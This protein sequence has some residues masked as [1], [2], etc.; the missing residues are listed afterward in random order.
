MLNFLMEV[1]V[2]DYNQVCYQTLSFVLFLLLLWFFS[3]HSL[4]SPP[5]RETPSLIGWWVVHTSLS[6]KRLSYYQLF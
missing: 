6:C 1:V 5:S 3:F 2:L 4:L